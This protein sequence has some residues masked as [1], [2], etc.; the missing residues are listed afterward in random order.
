M[1]NQKVHEYVVEKSGGRPMARVG[2]V[3]NLITFIEAGMPKRHYFDG[4]WV[5]DAGLVL[6]ESKIPPHLKKQA[7]ELPFNAMEF[8]Q[9]TPDVLQSCEF[10]PT[11]L[12][13][14]EYAAHLISD[15]MRGKTVEATPVLDLAQVP[16][17]APTVRLRPEDLPDGQYVV[18]ED[19]F[20][21]INSDG[22]P[23]KRPG[24]PKFIRKA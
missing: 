3:H 1:E 21:Q 7:E 6:D 12:P 20:V 14:R 15:H 24:R 4:K 5:N 19:G 2:R 11:E 22:S 16:A 8:A 17:L 9:R 10:C 23:R 18:D 13:S